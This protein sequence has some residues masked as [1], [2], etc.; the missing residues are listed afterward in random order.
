MDKN[1]VAFAKSV[2]KRTSA[3]LQGSSSGKSLTV[4]QHVQLLISQAVSTQ[5]LSRM[6][7]GWM[8]WL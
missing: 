3:K 1:R 6:Y 5:R 2:M 8:A 4:E 7:E